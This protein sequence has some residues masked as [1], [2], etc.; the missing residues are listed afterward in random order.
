MVKIPIKETQCAS[1]SYT[2]YTWTLIPDLTRT[3]HYK[4]NV[5]IDT[6]KILY[7]DSNSFYVR[8]VKYV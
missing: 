1:I 4:Y 5:P 3:L 7:S 2:S 8:R 6:T